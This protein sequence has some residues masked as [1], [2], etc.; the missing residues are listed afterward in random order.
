MV[1]E[2][3][4]HRCWSDGWKSTRLGSELK[5]TRVHTCAGGMRLGSSSEVFLCALLAFLFSDQNFPSPVAAIIIGLG[6]LPAE[7]T[8]RTRL[9]IYKRGGLV[10]TGSNT[11][12]RVIGEWFGQVWTMECN[13]SSDAAREVRRIG[14]NVG[15][16][17]PA[18]SRFYHFFPRPSPFDIVALMAHVPTEQFGSNIGR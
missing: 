15:F 14:C 4:H 10:W 9:I 13:E 11:E 17:M 7:Y 16:F 1:R 18:P 6:I 8:N 3:K 5:W 2:P 12:F